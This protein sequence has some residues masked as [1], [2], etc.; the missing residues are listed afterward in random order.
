L[1]KGKS[2]FDNLI[3]F[4]YNNNPIKYIIMELSE[5]PNNGIEA[6]YAE[7]C[8]LA[9]QNQNNRFN[10]SEILNPNGTDH[11]AAVNAIAQAWKLPIEKVRLA[12]KNYL[13]SGVEGFFAAIIAAR[14]S[15]NDK[16]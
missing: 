1:N 2:E 13:K 9:N 7:I 15:C 6:R 10:L 16:I 8:A 4:C 14:Q 11:E 12:V 3:V 5:S